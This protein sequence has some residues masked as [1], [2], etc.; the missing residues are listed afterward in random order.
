MPKPQQMV[1]ATRG[2]GQLI[3]ERRYFAVPQH[4]RDYAWPVGSVEQYLEDVIGALTRGDSDYFLGLVVLVGSEDSKSKRFEILD[5]QQRL[6]TTTM[7]FAAIRQWLR[8]NAFDKQAQ[9]IQNDFIGI[10]EIGEV[11]DEPRVVMN[12]NNQAVFQEIV[13]NTCSTSDIEKRQAEAGKYTSIRKLVDAALRCRQI[14]YDL[15]EKQGG[16]KEKRANILYELA[17]YLRDNVQV[18]CL[19]V[20]EPENAYMIF[21]ALNDRGIDLSVLDLLKN[22]L[23]RE[24]AGK[25]Q[26]QVQ[27]NWSAMMSRL[28]DRRADDF[29]KA[30][31]T[32]RYGRIQR[33]RL[34]HELKKIYK[35][36]VKVIALS[37]ELVEVAEQYASLEVA[38]SEIWK[39]YSADCQESLRSLKLLGGH[40]THPV[41]LAALARFSPTE[42]E[43]LLHHL[44]TLIVRYQLI[45]RGRTGRLEIRA[46][47]VAEKIYVSNHKTAAKVWEDLKTIIP[48]DDEFRQDFCTLGDLKAPISRW[49]LRELEAAQWLSKNPDKA[50]QTIAIGDPAKVNLEHVLPR[51]P[52]QGWNSILKGD[53][54][55]FE[56][57]ATKLGNLALLDKPT[58]KKL[59]S[60]SFAEKK[61]SFMNSEFLLTRELANAPHWDRAAIESRQLS[62]AVLA[63]CHW[64]I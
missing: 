64:P 58:N 21:E 62:M 39:N 45:G 55:I 47:T 44:V 41:I 29:L 7:I 61:K 15:A 5:G 56:D 9:Q 27:A 32:S 24:T 34:F 8:D 18:N 42:V 13:V 38:D 59:G 26:P 43:K 37:G 17:I 52:G 30:F 50:L 3:N 4:Q 49:L 60:Q 48:S 1:S 10:S 19:D 20:T 22:H 2:I 63:I 54:S 53:P 16:D 28:G 23:F 6:A 51:A 35:T 40:Q 46:A 25:N 12:L 33:G 36:K 57:C 31:W 11:L 14:I